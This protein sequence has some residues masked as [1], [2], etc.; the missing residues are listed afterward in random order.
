MQQRVEL[1][2]ICDDVMYSSRDPSKNHQ[3]IDFD[4]NILVKYAYIDEQKFEEYKSKKGAWVIDASLFEESLLN[5]EGFVA[6]SFSVALKIQHAIQQQKILLVHDLWDKSLG[7]EVDSSQM[8]VQVENV[9]GLK[10]VCPRIKFIQS[11]VKNARYIGVFI[12]GSKILKYYAKDSFFADFDDFKIV[13]IY[14]NGSFSQEYSFII[15]KT[16]GMS[17]T[18]CEQYAQFKSNV[19]SKYTDPNLYLITPKQERDFLLRDNFR[20]VGDF[21]TSLAYP[22]LVDLKMYPIDTKQSI[23]DF[24]ES[25]PL[26][27]LPIIVKP[28]NSRSCESDTAHTFTIIKNGDSLKEDL[29]KAFDLYC[30]G[31]ANLEIKMLIQRCMPISATLIKGYYVGGEVLLFEQASPE[32]PSDDGDLA[33]IDFFSLKTK[34]YPASESESMSYLKENCIG[35]CKALEEHFSLV[36]FGF[37]LLLTGEE[38]SI[39]GNF[40]DLNPFVTMKPFPNAVLQEAY[41]NIMRKRV[42]SG[43]HSK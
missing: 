34:S 8:T 23:S 6:C 39:V 26:S 15:S 22:N 13:P 40:I 10:G 33:H 41:R 7:K 17:D 4:D 11:G 3:Y 18:D 36:S 14:F 27:D 2:I 20:I 32:L 43:E 38:G 12:Q 21:L 31:N 29:E 28:N 16:A 42:N 30:P 35:F 9:Y 5:S 24:V 25:F 1:L 19:M 37:D